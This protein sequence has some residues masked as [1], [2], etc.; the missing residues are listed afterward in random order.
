MN[1]VSATA[2]TGAVVGV[3]CMM[4]ALATPPATASGP[5]GA[6]P[7]W[8]VVA[9]GLDNP[10]QLAFSGN[11]TLYVVESGKGGRAPCIPDPEDPKARRC[12]GTSGALTAVTHGRQRRVVTG[13]PSL[14]GPT[15]SS[16]TGPTDVSFRGRSSFVMSFGL[17]AAPSARKALPAA[18]QLLGTLA[19]GR[20]G[21]STV[22]R[23]A[24]VAAN[25]AKANPDR[26]QV[27]SNPVA[28][29]R[30][31]SRYLVADAGGNAV[32][33]ASRN[34]SF[35]TVAVFPVTKVLAPP[36][37]K[38]PPGTKIPMDA[39]PTAL[40]RG[41]QGVLYVSQLTGFPFP[42]GGAKIWTVRAGAKPVPYA[43]GLTNVTDLAFGRDGS[44]YAVQIATNGLLQGPKGSLVRVSR[45]GGKPTV[46][47][48]N[49]PSPYGVAVQGR[50]AYVSTCSV[51][52]GGGQVIRVPLP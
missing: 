11:G 13:L 38:L 12:F 32:V 5:A 3:A 18:G 41:R 23:F 19:S 44:L 29:L 46:I 42:V 21:S 45:T 35:A 31:G 10:R 28:V 47:A 14:A 37:L 16:A 36:V 24:D 39:V 20:L 1:G 52:A 43:K 9:T 6:A 8:K 51:C 48:G 30:H 2:K 50:S 22:T 40:A 17:G 49:L 27:D 7:G 15:G 34:G 33:S 26:K 4:A 25:E